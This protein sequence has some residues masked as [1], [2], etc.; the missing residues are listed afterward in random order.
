M[1][2]GKDSPRLETEWRIFIAVLKQDLIESRSLVR[3]QGHSADRQGEVLFER[4]AR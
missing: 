1:E 4:H 3:R 2:A